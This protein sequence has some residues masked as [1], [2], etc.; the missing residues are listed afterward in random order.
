MIVICYQWL[1]AVKRIISA[2]DANMGDPEAMRW[3]KETD[4]EYI[5]SFTKTRMIIML[6]R[7]I[8]MI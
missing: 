1:Y 2:E 4:K 6:M 8:M 3:D 5:E 7:M